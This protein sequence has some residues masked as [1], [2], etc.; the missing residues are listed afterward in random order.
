MSRLPTAAVRQLESPILVALPQD[1]AL[2]VGVKFL[3]GI[4]LAED[5]WRREE[6]AYAKAGSVTADWPHAVS[7]RG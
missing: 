7:D 1:P 3:G 4:K 6:C 5:D 2:K